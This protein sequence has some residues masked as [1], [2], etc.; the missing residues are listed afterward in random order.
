MC[1]FIPCCSAD[2]SFLW[3]RRPPRSTLFPYT[4]LFRSDTGHLIRAAQAPF[5]RKLDPAQQIRH[6]GSRNFGLHLK[7]HDNAK[8]RSEEHTSELQSLTNLVCRLLLEKKKKCIG[9]DLV[10]QLTA[11]E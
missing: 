3:L 9:Y 6:M 7:D 11:V 2:F 1:L 4:T 8:R 10:G 5:N